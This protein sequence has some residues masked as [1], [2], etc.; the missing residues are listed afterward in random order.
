[1]SKR[2]RSQDTNILSS[3]TP[4]ALA[5][6]LTSTMAFSIYG[7]I[8][9]GHF[10]LAL[11][12]EQES[13]HDSSSVYSV[14]AGLLLISVLIWSIWRMSKLAYLEKKLEYLQQERSAMQIQM[15]INSQDQ[16]DV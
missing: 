2:E 7:T 8:V 14:I 6:K 11:Y 9:G 4:S 5:Q 13:N 12:K 15:T 10:I 3:G 1:M 16:I